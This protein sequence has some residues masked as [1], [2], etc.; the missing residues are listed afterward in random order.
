MTIADARILHLTNHYGNVYQCPL[1]D[2]KFQGH[3][4][5]RY[6]EQTNFKC[7]ESE[8]HLV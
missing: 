1:Y 6:A 8:C 3:Y 2:A 4:D 5:D 7:S